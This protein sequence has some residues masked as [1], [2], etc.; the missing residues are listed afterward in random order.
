M[1]LLGPP[2]IVVDGQP[3]EVDTRKASAVLAVV[4][5]EGPQLRDRLASL[6]WPDSDAAH[7]AGSFR[8]TL[9][10]LNRAL[11]DG[12]LGSDRRHVRVVPG[13][14]DLD[15]TRFGSLI[16]STA[17]HGHPAGEACPDCRSPLRAAVAE[18]RG[19]FL[20]GFRVRDSAEFE[21]WQ[22]GWAERLRRELRQAL[23]RL[24]RGELEVGDLDEALGHGQAW[25]AADPLN[26]H[27][28]ARLMLIHA[29]R[30]ERNEAIQRYRD[31]VSVLDREL[32]VRPLERTDRLYRALLEGGARPEVPATPPASATPD[33]GR[34]ALEA[35]VGGLV[36]RRAE[37]EAAEHHVGIGSLLVVRGEAGIGKTRFVEE[38]EA[39]L[40]RQGAAVVVGRC[41]EGERGLS[42]GPVVDLVR[43]AVSV[44]GAG[45]RL[46]GL[47]RA[48]TTEASRVLPE[49]APSPP[50]PVDGE[51]PGAQT[52]LFDALCHVLAA[53]LPDHQLRVIVLEDLHVADVAT[54]EWVTYLAHR[55]SEHRLA[56]VL[57]G[58][59]DDVPRSHP[60]RRLGSDGDEQLVITLDRLGDEEVGPHLASM[61]GVRSD[62][63]ELTARILREADGLPLALVEYSRWLAQAEPGPDGDWPV[64]V[65][66]RAVV[67]S[68]L[69]ALSDTAR[70]LVSAAAVIGYEVDED[71]LR[72]V[73]G[74][75]EDETLA[76]L[77]ELVDRGVL[78]PG[79]AAGGL[80]FTHD[81]IRAV[82]YRDTNAARRRLLHA[83]VADAL[84]VRVGSRAEARTAGVIA[85]H[86]RLGGREE[87]AAR[88]SVRA[89]DHARTVFANTEA[90]QHYQQALAL[91][92]PEPAAVHARLARLEVL[93]GQ[94][95]AAL[96]AYETAAA[97]A[98]GP[99]ELAAIEHEL[100]ALHVRRRSLALGR[101]HLEAAFAGV[102]DQDDTLAARIAADLGLLELTAG[103]H[104]RAEGHVATA[105][106]LA[107]R[108]G[109][110][111][112]IAQARNIAGLLARHRG[113]MSEAM[114]HLEHAAALAATAA[115][116]TAYIAA[117]N[118]LALTTA[119]TGDGDRSVHLLGTALERCEQQGDR[120]RRAALLN[121]L[122]DLHH[123]FGDQERSM[124]LLKLAVTQFAEV[125][126][127]SP[128]EPEIW[129]LTEW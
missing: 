125:G 70:Q 76:G 75:T 29:R 54:L 28:H 107:E 84:A 35:G 118:N 67:R 5:V 25:L 122:A 50:S 99:L 52:R 80:G 27:A 66:V 15:V 93:D 60:L 101:V 42:F 91:G 57:T 111:Y 128:R 2:Q 97:R 6:L 110:R 120:H 115:D 123:R 61:L 79:T 12:V 73:A 126:G 38:L 78:R 34:R 26:E 86:A 51:P 113:R 24:T 56:L 62:L 13:S 59:H 119:E 117:L 53:A 108:A 103:E 21:D 102:G 127:P 77:E 40:H 43:S 65:G 88:W 87:E 95:P 18:Y 47:N 112:A 3:L 8:R 81:R 116:P 36:G 19:D 104:E 23:D 68:R 30:G 11:G 33:D 1:R 98:S 31:C 63:A 124:E 121:N 20:A 58:R 129:K 100:G 96:A 44:P 7:A 10:V 39:R 69:A 14:V 83:R 72:R 37:L 90:R 49:L 71:L 55:S 109:D 16:A 85:E 41:H 74:R 64:P 4:A 114:R 48:W 32:G 46:A 17:G 106:R 105:L 22:D 92:H 94:Y 89:G 45:E 82:A 9:S